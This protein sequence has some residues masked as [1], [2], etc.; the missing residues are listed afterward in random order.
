M[1][2]DSMGWDTDILSPL[3]VECSTD[4]L[5]NLT[6]MMS[7]CTVLFKVIPELDP[8]PMMCSGHLFYNARCVFSFKFHSYKF[9]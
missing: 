5:N 8:E 6:R 2:M 3:L 9:R 4:V 7:S 1:D